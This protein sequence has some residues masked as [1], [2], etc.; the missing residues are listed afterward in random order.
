MLVTEG[1][2]FQFQDRFAGFIHRLNGFLE[3]LRGKNCAEM[4]AGV[5]DNANASWNACSADSGNKNCSLCS[6]PAD[7]NRIEF[8]S[9]TF[10]TDVDIVAENEG[11]LY[12]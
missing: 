3:T 6:L 9:N 10:I 8:P 1:H 5:D 7:A 12:P 11:K 2:R 4:S